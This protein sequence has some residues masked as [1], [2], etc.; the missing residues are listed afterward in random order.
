MTEFYDYK[1]IS[2]VQVNQLELLGNVS[3]IKALL[4][5]IL[6]IAKLNVTKHIIAVDFH[7]HNYA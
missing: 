3:E 1:Y 2:E 6:N 7:Y 5:G 4:F